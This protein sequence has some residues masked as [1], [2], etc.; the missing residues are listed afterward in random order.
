MVESH[1]LLGRGKMIV[2]VVSVFQR[3]NWAGPGELLCCYLLCCKEAATRAPRTTHSMIVARFMQIRLALAGETVDFLET[4]AGD[5]ALKNTEVLFRI[6]IEGLLVDCGFLV[7]WLLLLLLLLVLV[8]LV[9]LLLLL[10][11]VV[12]VMLRGLVVVCMV[13]VGVEKKVL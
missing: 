8:V 13:V 6:Y 10:V 2:C 3:V 9:M 12:E 4:G 5:T 7:R 11:V 1:G